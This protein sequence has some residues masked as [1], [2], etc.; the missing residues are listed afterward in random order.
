MNE[1]TNGVLSA[2]VILLRECTSAHII[3]KANDAEI[4]QLQ[5]AGTQMTQ[6]LFPRNVL[7]SP[8]TSLTPPDANAHMA[9][10]P[11]RHTSTLHIIHHSAV[12]LLRP[13]DA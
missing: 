8:S 11:I 2:R 1:I 6:C 9:L 5:T 10:V 3:N 13:E 12:P 7:V 4:P